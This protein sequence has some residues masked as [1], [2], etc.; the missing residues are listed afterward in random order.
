MPLL[1]AVVGSTGR[2]TVDAEAAAR[3]AIAP[4]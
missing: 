3:T 1:G 2:L 4:P